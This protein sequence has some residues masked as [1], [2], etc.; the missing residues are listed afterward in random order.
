[1]TVV[2]L[3]GQRVVV[4]GGSSGVGL[5]TAHVAARAGAEVVVA[6][7]SA[8]GLAADLVQDRLMFRLW[9]TLSAARLVVPQLRTGGSIALTSGTIGL[10]PRRGAVLSATV[11]GAVETMARAL[12]VELAPG[13]RVNAI[14]P[15]VVRTPMWDDVP[16]ADRDSMFASLAAHPLTGKVAQAGQVARRAPV[17][18]DQPGGDRQRADRGP[19]AVL[20]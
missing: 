2:P 19:G 1:M 5:A 12:A 13:A 7:R 6:A 4:I 11:A 10:R 16:E 17:S 15:G 9:G 18:H 3:A 8:E 14:R 20:V